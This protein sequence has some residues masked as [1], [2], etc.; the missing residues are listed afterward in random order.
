[1]AC[2]GCLKVAEKSKADLAEG[3]QVADKVRFFSL[4][5]RKHIGIGLLMVNGQNG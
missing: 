3:I 4:S 2:P 5:K 1:M